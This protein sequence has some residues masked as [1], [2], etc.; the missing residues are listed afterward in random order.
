VTLI[1][2]A[3]SPVELIDVVLIDVVLID[4]V[5]IDVAF[6]RRT[7]FIELLFFHFQGFSFFMNRNHIFELLE[8]LHSLQDL[9]LNILAATSRACCKQHGS[10]DSESDWLDC[11]CVFRNGLSHDCLSRLAR[12]GA[13][14]FLLKRTV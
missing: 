1:R 5:L 14:R 3:E 7:V 9:D 2:D 13:L 4:V 10:V 12:D 11:A 8:N 6:T